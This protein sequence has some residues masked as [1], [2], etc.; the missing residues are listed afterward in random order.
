MADRDFN[1]GILKKVAHR[2][3]PMPDAPW[4]MTQTWHDLLFAHWP[5]S[6]GALREKVPPHFDLDLFEGSGWL[7][8]VPF[9]MTNVAPRGVPSLP[10]ISEFPELN[11]PGVADLT[12]RKTELLMCTYWP[13]CAKS[14]HTSV[15]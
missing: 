15:R 12:S 2:P 11:G 10:R 14:R 5:V 7:G 1:R 4:V 8:I 9:R 6:A 3:W 13:S